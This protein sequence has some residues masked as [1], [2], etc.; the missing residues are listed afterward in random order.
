[1]Y[2]GML[3]NFVVVVV[4]VTFITAHTRYDV[5]RSHSAPFAMSYMVGCSQP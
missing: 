1:M 2:M 3:I 4:F 5:G